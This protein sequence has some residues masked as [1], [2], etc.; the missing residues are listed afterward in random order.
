MPRLEYYPDNYLLVHLF[1]KLLAAENMEMKVLY[2]LASVSA[3]IC[4]DSVAICKSRFL[5]YC[6]DSFENSGNVGAV[7]SAY[8]IAGIDMKLGN[9][10]NMNGSLGIYILEG[11]DLF[12]FVY[13]S[14]GDVALDY[15]TENAIH[16]MLLSSVYDSV[17]FLFGFAYKL[18]LLAA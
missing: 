13:F 1:G 15:F 3:A 4:D 5:C 8:H 12:I 17:E 2:G 16:I 10:E 9:N 18:G 14:G 11:I 6:G 7:F